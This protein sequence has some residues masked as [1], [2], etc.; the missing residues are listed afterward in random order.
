MSRDMIL[1]KLYSSDNECGTSGATVGNKE[2]DLF[3][4]HGDYH[5]DDQHHNQRP[6][7][8]STFTPDNP[9]SSIQLR[10]LQEQIEK[11][12]A[13]NQ[14]LRIMLDQ[15]K[16][17]YTA[18]HRQLL[19]ARQ[20]QPSNNHQFKDE[21]N[22][23]GG[24]KLCTRQFIDHVSSREQDI[25]NAEILD[26]KRLERLLS[27]TTS[28]NMNVMAR[29]REDDTFI[30]GGKKRISRDDDPDQ[31]S[32]S[33]GEQLKGEE[34]QAAC[35]KARVS[36]RARSVAATIN[37]GCQWRKY[38]QKIAKG[39]PCPR[40]YYRC[41]MGTGCPVRKQVQR[42]MEDNTILITTYE[43]NHSHPLPA[44]AT[45]MANTTSAAASM[46]LS[47]SMT[48]VSNSGL[49][50]GLATLS[51]STPHPTITLDLTQDNTNSNISFPFHGSYRPPEV[52]GHPL[53]FSPK[54]PM[55][56]PMIDTVTSAISNDSYFTTALS[57]A[58]ASILGVSRRSN[59]V[60]ESH[61]KSSINSD[62]HPGF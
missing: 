56:L 59:D 22:G 50:P 45:A 16:T 48:S 53:Y 13:E 27:C 31:T 52:M 58:V 49:F 26:E 29:G 15:V 18:L 42:C 10:V 23:S 47:G 34:E 38:G 7:H 9:S 5:H 4:M 2:L 35:G 3:S 24:P 37:D 43:G 39:N 25:N 33:R 54:L 32:G 40:A 41:S 60:H 61:S 36:I 6:P 28:M 21:R 14:N 57:E 55:M 8:A 46:L 44:V 30:Q 20:K 12:K 51:T 11:S 19:S 62:Q 17:R 1:S